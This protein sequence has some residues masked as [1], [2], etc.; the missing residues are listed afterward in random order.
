MLVLSRRENEWVSI[1]VDGKVLGRITVASL[2]Y[3]RKGG[4]GVRLGF[5]FPK[6]VQIVRDN[7]K[8][9]ESKD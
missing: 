6:E 8:V 3:C 4:R 5:D 9:T 7:A 1:L 2:R